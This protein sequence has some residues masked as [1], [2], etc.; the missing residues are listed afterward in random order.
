MIIVDTEKIFA[1]SSLAMQTKDVLESCV[2]IISSLTE[3]NDW[4]CIE[5]DYVNESLLTTKS[6]VLSLN[7]NIDYFSGT[8]KNVASQFESFENAIP[9]QYQSLEN[10][11]ADYFAIGS[12][13]ITSNIGTNSEKI[14][15]TISKNVHVS[16]GLENYSLGSLTNDLKVCSFDDVDFGK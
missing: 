9:N 16:G 6:K 14:A 8:L 15:S 7:N 11:F 13:N 1:M 5:R 12:Q 10:S 3:H 4:N 2:K